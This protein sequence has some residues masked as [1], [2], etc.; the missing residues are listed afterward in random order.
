MNDLRRYVKEK[1]NPRPKA[2]INSFRSFGYNLQTAVADVIDN[3]ISA[4]ARN[5][6]MDYKW[7]GQESYI[8]ILDDGNGMNLQELIIALTP[9]SKDPEEFRDSKDLG[10]FGLGLKTASFSQ[11]KVLTVA[12]KKKGFNL[13]KRTWDLDYV[14]K[15]EE[16]VL[17]DYIKEE[18]QASRLADS[19]KGTV[20][21]WN[22]MDRLIGN[23]DKENEAIKNL[24]Y[25]ELEALER[26]LSLVF[27]KYMEANRL[28][29]YFKDREVIPWN[30][31]LPG[32][33]TQMLPPEHINSVEVKGF[34][35]PHI[36]KIPAAKRDE[37]AGPR[38]WYDQQGFYV[39]RNDRLLIDG[40]WLGMF[41]KND[42]SKLARIYV[43][44]P[45]DSDKDWKLDIKKS[46]ATPPYSLKKDLQRIGAAARRESAK[47]Y[48]FRGKQLK[49][50]PDLPDYK[51]Q[52]VWEHKKGRESV[53]YKINRNHPLIRQYI[54]R[55]ES[56][57]K[58][59]L[60]VIKLIESSI[61]IETIIH[62]QNEEPSLHELRKQKETPDKDII[63][64][65]KNLYH[66]YIKSG[67]SKNQALKMV[68]N[69]EPFN[70]FP[71]LHEYLNHE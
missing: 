61:P 53:S 34:I 14:N 35:L 45:N 36:S 39:Y 30:P 5:I 2:T 7:A 40:S 29:L 57:G 71:V 38:G 58:D 44:F 4:D 65:A 42:H 6:W 67:R 69:I 56:A 1:A 32:F 24:F 28:K 22:N 59:F 21:I 66:T 12:T 8:S 18:E 50:N 25:E 43:N 26:H 49:R 17:L 54:A 47:V 20:V 68:L 10:R 64:L 11:C 37:C 60:S 48:S 46:Q 63:D 27:H 62:F 33:K 52:A 3:S 31:F 13:I 19:E 9:G 15:T 41:G 51:F 16:W 23:A 55:N 70:L